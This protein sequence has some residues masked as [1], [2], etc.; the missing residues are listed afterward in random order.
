M[1]TPTPLTD[2]EKEIQA[3]L[4]SR[5][6]RGYGGQPSYMQRVDATMLRYRFEDA[7]RGG[8]IYSLFGGFDADQQ[9]EWAMRVLNYL[10]EE[11]ISVPAP[12]NTACNY[13]SKWADAKARIEALYAETFDAARTEM[14]EEYDADPEGFRGWNT[15]ATVEDGK[16]TNPWDVTFTA[17]ADWFLANMTQYTV[18][19]VW[20]TC[21]DAASECVREHLGL[22]AEGG[23]DANPQR[24]VADTFEASMRNL[25][26]YI[27]ACVKEAAAA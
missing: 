9:V 25:S 21:F 5:R 13:E 1:S 2:T 20:Q 8:P 10:T 23:K 17:A 16:V 4:C 12:S 6:I 24:E 15:E 11:R 3:R 19:T 18:F 27:D 14:Q 22:W 26:D 7:H